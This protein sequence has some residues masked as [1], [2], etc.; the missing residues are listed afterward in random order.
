MPQSIVLVHHV[1][2]LTLNEQNVASML[3]GGGKKDKRE[4]L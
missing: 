4:A 1:D 2:T 3:P